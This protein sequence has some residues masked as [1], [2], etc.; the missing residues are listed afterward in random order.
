MDYRHLSPPPPRAQKE[1]TKPRRHAR[2]TWLV[3]VGVILFAMYLANGMSPVFSW[4]G[5]LQAW[6]IRNKERFTMLATLGVI[7]CAMCLLYRVLRS[8]SNDR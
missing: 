7:G 2:L 5:L 4:E 8:T 3:V 1:I 6:G